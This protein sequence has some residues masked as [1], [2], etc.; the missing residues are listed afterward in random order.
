MKARFGIVL[1]VLALCF[2]WFLFSAMGGRESSPLLTSNDSPAHKGSPAIDPPDPEEIFLEHVKT[3]IIHV[4]AGQFIMGNIWDENQEMNDEGPPHKVTLDEF[5]IYRSEFTSADLFSLLQLFPQYWLIEDQRVL[6]KESRRLLLDIDDRNSPFSLDSE[7]SLIIKEGREEFPVNEI[8]WYGAAFACNLLSELMGYNPV[9]NLLNMQIQ[10]QEGVRLPTEAQW[11][12][13]AR[14]AD[15]VRGPYSGEIALDQFAWYGEYSGKSPH[16]VEQKLPNALGLF[17][18]SG[19]LYEWCQ[20]WYGFT[21]YNESE[22]IN[23][24][25]PETGR[26]K[27]IRGGAYNDNAF[28]LRISFRFFRSPG[29]EQAYI[30]FRPVF[31]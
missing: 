4:P 18:L 24:Q 6:C 11:E 29:A 15:P 17:D 30:G 28:A 8:T 21:Y 3:R 22:E 9:Y 25:G 12:W 23:P 13:A 14:A 7:N 10:S 2:I 20:D 16:R 1:G 31:P 5:G 27:V 19:N 26:D